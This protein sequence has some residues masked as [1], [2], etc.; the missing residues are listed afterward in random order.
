MEVVIMDKSTRSLKVD[1]K[2][3]EKL[4]CTRTIVYNLE[5]QGIGTPY[6]ESLT[7]YIARLAAVH[8]VSTAILLKKIIEPK[9][10]VIHIKEELIK[11]LYSNTTRYIN[12]NN[13]ITLDYVKALELLT[14][15]EDLRNLTMLNWQGI[16]TK[17]II[18]DYRK[19]CPSCFKQMVTN[20]EEIYEPLIW[21]LIAIEKCDIHEIRL[22]DT[23]NNCKKKLPFVHSRIIV[24]YCQYCGSWLGDKTSFQ[25]EPLTE[26]EKFS[27]LN[28]KELIENTCMLK[29]FPSKIFISL[30]LKRAIKEGGFTSFKSLARYLNISFSSFDNYLYCRN[31]PDKYNLIKIV[32]KLNSTI[33]KLTCGENIRIVDGERFNYNSRVKTKAPLNRIEYT[34]KENLKSESPKS[35]SKISLE[36]G[37][38]RDTAK[39]YFPGL[40]EKLEEKYHTYHKKSEMITKAKI[41]TILNHCLSEDIPKSLTKLADEN[42]IPIRKIRR[43]FPEL[44]KEVSYRYTTYLKERRKRKV[45]SSS[46]EIQRIVNDLHQKGIYPSTWRVRQ[47]SDYKGVFFYEET[48]ES[49]REIV[50]RLGYVPKK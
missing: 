46:K 26:I 36:L 16:L 42:R 29:F 44:S 14:G 22:E 43:Y 6:I 30:L 48:R 10:S 50:I 32:S 8:S 12:K 1:T 31:I 47:I 45:E 13:S 19:W 25:K 23:C 5:P 7:S 40:C 4:Y 18:G 33:Y 2:E 9:L 27:A 21:Y 24:G 38:G 39:K 11:G 15:R 17:K 34:L 3:V 28:Y 35:L 20:S 49:W 37:C 41:H